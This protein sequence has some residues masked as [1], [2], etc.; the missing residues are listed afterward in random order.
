MNATLWKNAA[1][2]GRQ[3]AAVEPVSDG[4]HLVDVVA[5]MTGL[6]ER[7]VLAWRAVGVSFADI[8]EANGVDAVD[9]IT[10]AFDQVAARLAERVSEGIMT[11]SQRLDTLS[12]AAGR[13]FEDMEST[14]RV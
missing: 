4:G 1:G 6:E 8:A 2:I 12:Y 11:E 13:L 5:D 3:T 9:V 14:E 10:L 7:D